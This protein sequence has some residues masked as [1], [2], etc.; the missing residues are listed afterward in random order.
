MANTLSLGQAG[1][2]LLE[3]DPTVPGS[4]VTTTMRGTTTSRIFD[5]RNA[6]GSG[7][8]I[9]NLS[10]GT[11][12][13]GTSTAG[14]NSG[15]YSDVVTTTA[16]VYDPTAGLVANMG[17]GRDTLNL[18]G[19]ADGASIEMDASQDSPTGGYD[20]LNAQKSFTNSTA[21]MGA[22]NDTV[23][24]SGSA[25]GSAFFLGEGNDSLYIAGASQGV[26]A[27]GGAGTD[28]M[29]FVGAQ[30]DV[31]AFGGEGN[32]SITFTGGISG[33]PGY[34]PFEFGSAGVAGGAGN[35]TIVFGTTSSSSNFAIS[36]GEGVDVLKL[37]GSID[38][39]NIWLGGDSGLPT[40]GR[41]SVTMTSGSISSS[42]IASNNTQGDT[43]VF[44]STAQVSDTAFVMGEGGD[45]L[46][47]GGSVFGYGENSTI[48]LGLGADT[49]TFGAN[50]YV[51]GYSISL[52]NDGMAD[53]ISLLGGYEGISITGA[54][55]FD[56]LYV[57][58]SQYN[59]NALDDSWNDS[60]TFD[61]LR[62]S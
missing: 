6:A 27:D 61:T 44:G 39:A 50:S 31:L 42:Q 56:I 14:A 13:V 41:D 12:W 16:N 47:F 30:T 4:S 23:R 7:T 29:T 25:D 11:D 58:T 17:D 49:L 9:E 3:L 22:G 53:I 15:D 40:V 32:D 43:V 57:G 1:Y 8:T 62:F 51:A 28:F 59:Y 36:T 24:V 5:V 19:N 18:F 38:N 48:D 20:L 54:D 21:A 34:Q 37:N 10:I 45:S 35:D 26:T 2:Q 52:G 60:L 33:T 46:V 55:E